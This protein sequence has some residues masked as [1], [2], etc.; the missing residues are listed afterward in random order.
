VVDAGQLA[1]F[2]CVHSGSLP[3]ATV[4]WQLN[5]VDISPSSDIFIVTSTLSHNDP[6]RVSST[7]FVDDIQLSDQGAYTCT[8]TNPLIQTSTAITPQATLTVTRKLLTD[9][10]Y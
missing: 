10:L 4:T 8:A 7:L 1:S 6:P 9:T 3:P 5:G 2:Y